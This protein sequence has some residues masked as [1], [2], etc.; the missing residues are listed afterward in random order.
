MLTSP[1]HYG[2]RACEAQN[3]HRVPQRE[4]NLR[5][6]VGAILYPPGQRTPTRISQIHEIPYDSFGDYNPDEP[7]FEDNESEMERDPP[8]EGWRG[9]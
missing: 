7:L 3:G 6:S 5:K 1:P 4:G 2:T 9:P 8:F